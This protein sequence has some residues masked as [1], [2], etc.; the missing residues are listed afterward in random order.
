MSLTVIGDAFG[1]LK[2]IK[3]AVWNDDGSCE[4][5]IFVSSLFSEIRVV[6]LGIFLE[7]SKNLLRRILFFASEKFCFSSS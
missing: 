3:S 7:L 4:D 2:L 6:N 1:R 5:V